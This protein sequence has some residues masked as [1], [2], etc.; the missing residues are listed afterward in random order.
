MQLDHLLRSVL[1]VILLIAFGFWLQ[2]RRFFSEEAVDNLTKLVSDYLIP[3]TIFTTFMG[4]DLRPE[5]FGLAACVFLIQLLLLGSGFLTARLFGFRRRFAPLYP[6]AFAFGFMAIPLFSTVFGLEHM[7]TLTSMGVGHELFIG[8]VFMPLARLY[9]KG[10]GATPRQIGKNLLSPLFLMIFLALVLQLSGLRDQVAATD[11]GGGIIDTIG[12]LGGI[13]STL[14]LLTVG[15][16]IRLDNP[17]KL[18]ESVRL[19]VWRYLLI[20]VISYAVKAL[21]MDPMAGGDPFFGA[22]FF[23]LFWGGGALDAAVALL[24]GVLVRFTVTRMRRASANTFFTNVCASALLAAPP[25]LL[26]WLGAPVQLDRIIIGAIMLLVPG[27]AITNAMRD[28]LSGDFLTALTRIGEVLI[29]SVAIAIGIAIPVGL[30][31]MLPGGI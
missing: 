4:L 3:C 19:V 26:D 22:A 21:L 6:C 24:C 14:I 1:P 7:G 9:L 28:V 5:H 10:D 17:A 25:V 16:R 31:R 27:I 8:L 12:Q 13:S 2:R 23:T 20:F 29:V 30:A 18:R 15:Y 11:L